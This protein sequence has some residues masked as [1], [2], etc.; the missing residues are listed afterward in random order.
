MKVSARVIALIAGWCGAISPVWAQN[1]GA[2]IEQQAQ[3]LSP[4]AATAAHVVVTPA[5]PAPRPQ[6]AP[7]PKILGLTCDQAQQSVDVRRANVRVRCVPGSAQGQPSGTIDRQDPE[8]GAPVPQSRVIVG[9]LE[10][11]ATPPPDQSPASVTV[12]PSSKTKGHRYIVPQLYGQTCKGADALARRSGFLGVKCSAIAS[13]AKVK[14][15]IVF[16]QKPKADSVV[17]KPSLIDVGIKKAVAQVAVP[18]I[19]GNTVRRAIMTLGGVHLRGQIG[20]ISAAA[21][22]V[23]QTQNPEAKSVVPEGTIVQLTTAIVVPDL[24]GLRCEAA[25][26]LARSYGLTVSVCQAHEPLGETNP[27]GRVYA[28]E[29]HAGI[30]LT[31][32]RTATVQ[33]AAHEVPAVEGERLAHAEAELRAKHLTPA[34]D[35]GA[36][37]EHRVVRTQEPKAGALYE[38]PIR[39][40]LTTVGLSVVPPLKDLSCAD[41]AKTLMANGLGSDCRVDPQWWS[42]GTPRVYAQ[43]PVPGNERV[44]STVIIAQAK[45]VDMGKVSAALLAVLTAVGTAV[46]VLRPSM[47]LTV[48]P[49]LAPEVTIREADKDG[50]DFAGLSVRGE[51]DPEGSPIIRFTSKGDGS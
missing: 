16:E 48:Q 36:A 27:L 33:I 6:S 5:Q 25:R 22:A 8:A 38:A 10:P 9:Y 21:L 46:M 44:E 17:S 14:M 43:T 26:A 18:S 29:P 11:D 39:V 15:G 35:V 30:M 37:P 3:A 49:D 1:N 23:I 47:H 7:T 4:A 40:R 32:I 28:Q 34:P 13:D 42:V 2:Q 31:T 12:P 50:G 20:G 24:T 45:A 19:V 41:V 51:A